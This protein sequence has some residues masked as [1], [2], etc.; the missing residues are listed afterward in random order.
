MPLSSKQRTLLHLACQRGDGSLIR[1]E[2]LGESAA[3]S[4]SAKLIAEGCVEPALVSDETLIWE[5]TQDG[6]V[7]LRL[8][9]SGWAAIGREAPQPNEP[10]TA[11][12]LASDP[13]SSP[14][15]VPAAPTQRITKQAR[16]IALLQRSEGAS[17]DELIEATG[18]LPHSTRAALT[19]LRKKGHDLVRDR[20]AD[21]AIRYRLAA[22]SLPAAP[23]TADA[24]GGIEG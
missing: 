9:G 11:L 18:W 1:P 4:L 12:P 15:L 24:S 3:K 8:T 13:A 10:G 21:R 2:G 5:E 23:E 6:P 16:V 14:N 17:L 22:A 19:G 20:G 7:G